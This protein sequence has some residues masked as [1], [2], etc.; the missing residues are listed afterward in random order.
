MEY[1]RNKRNWKVLWQLFKSTF[2]L[3]AFTF[4]G[5]FVIVSLMKKKFVE[6]LGWLDE[7]EMLDITAIAQSSPGPIP[8]NAS[9][10]LGYRM[11]GIL[12]SIVAVVGTSIPPIAIISVISS[13]YVKF[14]ESQIIGTAL[15]VMRAGV[16]AVICDVVINL[17]TNVIKTGQVL[18][19]AL[20][21][22]AFIMTYVLGISAI[23]VILLC[24]L[25]GIVNLILDIKNS[26]KQTN[27]EV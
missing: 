6:E 20:M 3:S 23:T 11:Q 19:I 13:F 27:M 4:G 26:K 2:V 5:G 25:V 8:I 1:L 9:V 7:S 17:A 10:I 16:A 22:I 14:R 24:I 12:G 21:I 18:Y 15:M